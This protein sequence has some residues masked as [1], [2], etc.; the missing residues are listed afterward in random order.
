MSVVDSELYQELEKR[1]IVRRKKRFLKMKRL[2]QRRTFR[3]GKILGR[4]FDVDRLM[5]ELD[6]Q[7]AKLLNGRTEMMPLP[8]ILKKK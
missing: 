6:I 3:K 2:K 8:S 1:T 7:V 5:K 4:R